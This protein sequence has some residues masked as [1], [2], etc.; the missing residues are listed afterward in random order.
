MGLETLSFLMYMQNKWCYNEC[1]KLFDLH[2]GHHIWDKFCR[3]DLQHFMLE[4]DSSC[5]N[6]IVTRAN[7]SY[8]GRQELGEI[9]KNS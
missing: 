1:I 4:L 7:E 3:A 5:F 6:K 2:L 8:C 9:P